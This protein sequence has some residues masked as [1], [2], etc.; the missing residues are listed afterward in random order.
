MTRT[1]FE[2]A[3]LVG[4][5]AEGPKELMISGVAGIQEAGP[6]DITF[7]ANPKYETFLASSNAG[8]VIV[9]KDYRG[10]TKAAA[11]RVS[12]PYL[13]FALISALFQSPVEIDR[14]VSPQASIHESA[15]LGQDVAV[16][17]MAY[18]GPGATVGSRSVLYP[19]ACVGRNAVVGEDCVLHPNVVVLDRCII[20]SRV[21]LHSGTVI[22]SD[23]FGYARDVD[24]Q[25][26]VPQLGIVQIEDDVEIGANCTV[27]R[28]TLGRTRI[29]RGVKLDN[30][31]QVAH[32]VVIGENT[33]IAAQAGIAGS[34]RIGADVQIGGQVG[35]VGHI[36]VGDRTMIAAQSG[37]TRPLEADMVVSG[38]PALPHQVTIRYMAVLPKLPQLAKRV[39]EL[40]KRLR[41]LEDKASGG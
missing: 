33:V 1:L 24:R 17:P 29:C 41:E 35:F 28:A 39:Q 32:N 31:V 7:L 23:G 34:S 16:Y 3:D 2:L 36:E 15:S 10:K 13:A 22:G 5:E 40:E 20:G 37:V 25:V 14:S 19:G 30:L 12:N 27:D 8:A 6:G 9:K 11:L 26:K 21:I 38:T 4:G 18:V